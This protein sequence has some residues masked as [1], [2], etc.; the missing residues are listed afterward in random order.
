MSKKFP[1]VNPR[2]LEGGSQRG[3]ASQ[4]DQGYA[5]GFDH[6]EIG[7]PKT[8]FGNYTNRQYKKGYESGY[9][10]AERSREERKGV[11]SFAE[12]VSAGRRR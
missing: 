7:A 5:D 4:Y 10:A 6:A 8:V 3:Y 2:A 11:R 12:A 1:T 9:S